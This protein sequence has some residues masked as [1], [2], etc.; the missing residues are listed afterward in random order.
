MKARSWLAATVLGALLVPAA[1]RAQ[2]IEG[3]FSIA[4]QAGTQ[5]ELGG[6][7][8]KGATGT[9]FGGKPVTWN[10]VSY[11]DVYAPDVRLQGFVGYGLSDR[12]EIIA[13]GTYYKAD[14]T[15]VEV[16]QLE[17]DP[18]YVFFDD[19]GEYEEAGAELGLRFYI[20]AAG[21]LKSYVAPIVGARWLSETYVSYEVPE[22]GSAIRNVPL[23]EKST[24]PVFGLDIGFNFDLGEHFF[25][26]VDTGLRYQGAPKGADG[27]SGFP[28]IDDSDGRWSAPVSATIGVR[29]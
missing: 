11:K 1:S 17:E 20:A 19:Y 21:R 6:D 7:L 10:S 9:I 22:A 2:G 29:F 15:A 3:R 16:G 25:V 26:G 14:G 28:Q 8:L 24:V 13:R 23:H 27:L 4:F 18:V 12:L 5:S